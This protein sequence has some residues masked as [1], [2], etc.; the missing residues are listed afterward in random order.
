M[1]TL[2][3]TLGCLWFE[4]EIYELNPE[5][6]DQEL[7]E[8]GVHAAKA[9]AMRTNSKGTVFRIT[10]KVG[11]LKIQYKK[12]KEKKSTFLNKF[13]HIYSFNHIHTMMGH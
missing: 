6:E 3:D 12:W 2:N 4:K 13:S 5:I 9:L 7:L 10:A 1:G 8:T 11:Q